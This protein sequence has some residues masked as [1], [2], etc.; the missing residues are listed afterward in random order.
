[1]NRF[2]SLIILTLLTFLPAQSELEKGMEWYNRRAEGSVGSMAKADP[3]GR[4]IDHLEKA[5]SGTDGDKAALMLMKALYFKGEYTT[6]DEDEKKEIFDR[7]KRFAEKYVSHYPDSAPFRYWF[8]VNL[9]S[10][11]KAYGIITAAREGVADLMKEHSEKIIQLDPDYEHG[12]GYFMLGAV[13]YSSPYIPFLLSWP[14]NDEAIVWL[15]KAV[16]TGKPRLVQMIYLA[17][18]LYEDGQ[19]KEAI[20]ILEKVKATRPAAETLVENRDDIRE[21]KELL[22]KYR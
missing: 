21:A 3:I 2:F 14:D 9:G 7:G 22:R 10:W 13:H 17:Q 20:S 12:G 1:M 15:Q 8:L 11:S 6:S 5:L 18:A 19:E 16:A 4:A